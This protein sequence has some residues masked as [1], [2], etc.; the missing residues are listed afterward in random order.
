MPFANES[1]LTLDIRNHFKRKKI[2]Y[3]E[4]DLI[5]V[6]ISEQSSKNDVWYAVLGLRDVGTEKCIP[7]L[8]KTG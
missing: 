1:W 4:D 2:A 8:K 6:L 3:K 5:D 7:Y